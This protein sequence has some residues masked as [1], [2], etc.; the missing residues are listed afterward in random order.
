MK[1]F[2]I[3]RKT[4][5]ILANLSLF[6]NTFLPFVIATQPAYA[7]DSEGAVPTIS[8]PTPT[9]TA[10]PTVTETPVVTEAPT[11]I[12]T[13]T[14]VPTITEVPSITPTET[15]TPTIAVSYTHL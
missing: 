14:I 13:E 5:T 2:G 11:A 7:Q 4:A 9:E 12:P 1:I 15:A 10:T 6:L 8:E 3:A